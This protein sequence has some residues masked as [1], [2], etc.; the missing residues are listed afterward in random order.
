MDM[1]AEKNKVQENPNSRDGN[2][3]L[4]PKFKYVQLIFNEQK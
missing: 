2:V 3:K 1:I 4:R